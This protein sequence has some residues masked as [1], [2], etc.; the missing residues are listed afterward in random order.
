MDPKVL[1]RGDSNRY[2]YTMC[3][4]IL[5]TIATIWEQSNCPS[6]EEWVKCG[7]RTVEYYSSFKRKEILTYAATW[8]NPED[9]M[10]REIKQPQKD[11]C[12]IIVLM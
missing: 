1:K 11:N 5:F 7:L 8:L 2:L 10:P 9:V 12:C 6:T 3:I 4:V